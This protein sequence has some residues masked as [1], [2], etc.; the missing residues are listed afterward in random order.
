ME[1]AHRWGDRN[2]SRMELA[3]AMVV[4]AV[5]IGLFSRY[6]LLVFAR[7][8][9]NMVDNTVININTS[10]HYRAA[11]ALMKNDYIE[12]EQLEKVN[13]MEGLRSMPD[14]DDYGEN[15]NRL[16]TLV[17]SDINV[18][19]T[20]YGGIV[21]SN[22]FEIQEI[23]H[24]YFN[25]EENLLEYMVSNDEF[26]YSE[27]DGPSRIRFRVVISFNDKNFNTEYDPNIDEFKMLSL[28][29]VDNYVW[30]L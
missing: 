11:L 9:K 14:V 15:I 20:N 29:S 27:I 25:I 6:M 22:N 30:D 19:V 7:A 16:Q 18:S 17:S 23:G 12:L 3:T 4:L 5:M 26:F 24:W 10:L 1:L 13:P 2:L 21:L 28:N 8:E